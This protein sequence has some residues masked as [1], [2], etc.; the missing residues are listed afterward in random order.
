[1]ASWQFYSNNNA[2]SAAI[3]N[4]TD[5]KAAKLIVR[6]NANNTQFYQQGISLVKDKNYTL[7]FEGTTNKPTTMDVYLHRH[8]APYSDLGLGQQGQ[9]IRLTTSGSTPAS[10]DFKATETTNNGRLRF[11]LVGS[12][13]SEIILDNIQL[14]EKEDDNGG[15]SGGSGS[16]GSGSG[17]SGSG[18]SGSGGSGSGG[19]GSGGGDAGGT[20]YGG[21]RTQGV[22]GW[23]HE[24]NQ[25]VTYKEYWVPHDDFDGGCHENHAD[26]YVEPWGCMKTLRFNIPDDVSRALKAEI[27]LDYWRNRDNP[28]A[29]FRLNNGQ[30][31]R[32]T[33]GSDWSR[34]PFVKEIPLNELK[35][36]QNTIVLPSTDGKGAHHVHDI[37]IRVY[38]DAN[39]P[40]IAGSG[41]DVTPPTGRLTA[42]A[43][44]NGTHNP[45]QGGTLRV[46]NNRLTFAAE[47]SGAK[48][49]EFHAY[50]DGFDE[51]NN[52]AT[53]D[54]HS[55]YRNNWHKGGYP[56]NQIPANGGTINHVGTD[57][58]GPYQVTWDVSHL[59]NQPGVKFKIR[60]VD[61]NGN[62]REA[63]GGV[64]APF[65]LSRSY[66][67]DYHMD[68]NFE[69][70][71]LCHKAQNPNQ[72]DQN[73]N[74]SL[75]YPDFDYT[76]DLGA[77][78]NWGNVQRALLIGNYWRNPKLT[79][80]GQTTFSAFSGNEDEWTMSV[81]ENGLLNAL[82]TGNSQKVV[83]RYGYSGK[84]FGEFVEKPGPMLVLHYK[85]SSGGGSGSGGS[86]SGGSGSGGSGSGGSGSGGS[87][88]GGSGSGGSGSGGSGSGGS[89]SGGTAN[90]TMETIVSGKAGRV[91]IADMDGDGKNDI[92]A[93]YWGD[94]RG[95]DRK[96]GS[97]VWYRYPDWK[98][99]T[100]HSGRGYFGDE[101]ALADMDR[102]G[103]M[104]VVAPD[105]VANNKE[106]AVFW[107]E[108]LSGQGSQWREHAVA[109]NLK[110]DETKGLYVAD[111]DGNGRLDI[112]DRHK[113]K[114]YVYYQT[115]ANQWQTR[116]MDISERENL[117]MGDVDNDGDMDAVMNGFWREN[118]GTN[119]ANW[120]EHVFDRA[121]FTESGGGF[122]NWQHNAAKIVVA[123]LNADGKND[124][125]MTHSEKPGVKLRW[126]STNNPKGSWQKHEMEVV[127]YGHT[128]QVADFNNDGRPDIM[129]AQLHNAKK[130][131]LFEN[132]GPTGNGD[133]NWNA[134]TISTV[135]S[136]YSGVAGDVGS[137]GTIDFVSPTVWDHFEAPKQ[138]ISPKIYMLKN[139]LS[140]DRGG[141]GSLEDWQRHGPVSELPNKSLFV[142]AADMDGD[143]KKDLLAGPYWF[144]NP[145]NLGGNWARRTIGNELDNATLT[146][147]FDGDG[148]M[149]IFGT[150][151]VDA[152]KR[153]SELRWAENNGNG[154]FTVHN[155]I[156]Q[157]PGDF[158]QGA[159]L[160]GKEIFLS[161]HKNGNGVNKITIPSNPKNG[162]WQAS[163]A[164]TTNREEDL[165]TG[166]INKDGRIDLLLGTAWLERNANGSYT[167]HNFGSVTEGMEDRNDL[168]DVD[169]DGD[170][171]AVVA[172][173]EGQDVQLFKNPL[174]NG[175][176]PEG[177]W[178]RSR[179]GVVDGQGFSMD[180][181]DID[182]DGD[183]DVVIG[184]HKGASQNRLLILENNGTASNWPMHVIDR[185]PANVI[186]HHD[187][188]QLVDLD[189]DGDL[190]IISIGWN[191]P[192]LWIFE[193]T[194]K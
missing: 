120:P 22:S 46:D 74:G 68:P 12:A 128:L 124:I 3:V 168:A 174:S 32:S 114:F 147:D 113:D 64:S 173:E 88:S 2:N 182:R 191:N 186:D 65:T 103:D 80:N 138:G 30:L 35:K 38:H 167:P 151:W 9:G 143:G 177:S 41:S 72:C 152:N 13:N 162:Q 21:G 125:V 100:I 165:S 117:A 130:V 163:V 150:I 134:R 57:G 132:N 107:Y 185:Q 61:E 108:N 159:V 31:H 53:K 96:N 17:G 11:W 10:F 189:G 5:G 139:K 34:T 76:L 83:I 127:D 19:S 55:L 115:G 104:D 179:I 70:A 178:I 181:G 86:G 171:D 97:I 129:T 93:H 119:S 188:S 20:G 110:G 82:K 8:T 193:N 157:V 175:G 79:I 109:N 141:N 122:A 140:N 66:R 158:L 25:D 51:D 73:N 194:D 42:I 87:G 131:R 145:G 60:A 81:R 78:V 156:G 15:G 172:L 192:K 37:M 153:N 50:Y 67:V 24:A 105:G 45:S 58:N 54:W 23:I 106:L 95:R 56:S 101:I 148:D 176:N 111:L 160:S 4:H 75:R 1:M 133:V 92:V 121:F 36:G 85:P 77:S 170:L 62:V 39:H 43:D 33:V 154:G 169:G 123:D 44:D 27:Y 69:D 7:T 142:L 180:T 136:A 40:L 47:A 63:A 94:N 71:V 90:F 161:W 149:D 137:D 91:G 26:W 52:G 118:P 146:G 14:L 98:A 29:S 112:M 48:Y 144:K 155:N 187:G 59:I 84:G 18:G 28:A 89:G 183:P 166:D 16:G 164:S 99:T 116:E 126:Y 102:D 49:V 184:E 6:N 190:D 135:E